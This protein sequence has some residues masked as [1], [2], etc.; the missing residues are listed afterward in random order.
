MQK[1]YLKY[2]IFDKEKT[3]AAHNATFAWL[4]LIVLF[5]VKCNTETGGE[6]TI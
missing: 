5:N 6:E 3:K 1:I 4:F 2:Y